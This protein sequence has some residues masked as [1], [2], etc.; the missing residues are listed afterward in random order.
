MLKYHTMKKLFVLLLLAMVL[1]MNAFGQSL[2]K[3]VQE[4]RKLYAQAK[5]DIAEMDL[6]EHM[7]C[8]LVSTS[9]R[10]MPAIGIQKE[11]LTAYFNNED[12]DE[13]WYPI[14]RL[15]FLTRKYNAAARQFYEEYLFDAQTGRL[16]FVF[17]QGDSYVNETKD[18]TRYY[19]G[20]E[21]L[22]SENIKGERLSEPDTILRSAEA[23]RSAATTLMAH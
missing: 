5:Q 8:R 6:E 1:P 11:T 7:L 19:F 16:I 12:R 9:Q 17:L 21:G 13:D 20:E 2:P 10:N 23:L 14:F 15:F 3:T 18:E 22:I 4:V